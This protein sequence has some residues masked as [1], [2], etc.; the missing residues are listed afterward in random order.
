M[1]VK[2]NSKIVVEG[3]SRH[4]VVLVGSEG[5]DMTIHTYLKKFLRCTE[6][7]IRR[8]KRRED[9]VCINSEYRFMNAILHSGDELSV[10]LTDVG[11]LDR[12]SVS[13]WAKPPKDM[14]PLQILYED[15]DLIFLNKGPGV[16]CHP[17]PGHY[18][19]TLSNQVADHLGLDQGRMFPIGRLD[20]DTSGIVLFAKNQDAASIMTNEREN[21]NYEKT[22]LAWVEGEVTMDFDVDMPIRKIS[23]DYLLREVHPDG[24]EAI[25]HAKVVRFDKARNRTLLSIEIEHGRTHQIRVHMAYANH[26]ICGDVLY[27]PKAGEESMKLMAYR[28]RYR[29]PYIWEEKEIIVSNHI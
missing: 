23:E 20:M 28:V 12:D 5:E 8:V 18:A 22:Y 11:F 25:T 17:S 29:M 15:D 21:G 19:D 9:G 14:P 2:C 27:N 10:R 3:S 6:N 26:P 7:M 4:V 24:Q 16:C 13:I 1:E